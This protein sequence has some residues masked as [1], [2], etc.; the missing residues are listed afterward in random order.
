MKRKGDPQK[1]ESPPLPPLHARWGWRFG[2][3]SRARLRRQNLL[4]QGCVAASPWL[5][6]MAAFG[7]VFL[8]APRYLRQRGTL[9]ELPAAPMDEGSLLMM[10]AVLLMPLDNGA[11]GAGVL[12][13]HDD[14]R[15]RAENPAELDRFAESLA[16][17]VS[18]G[19]DEVVLLADGRVSHEWVM[20][21]AHAA[22]KAGMRRVNIAARQKQEK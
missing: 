17:E 3:T 20:A 12:V 18:A 13:L 11:E 16:R 7:M 1:M 8:A 14:L 2:A 15:H 21:V 19:R 4:F 5:A 9:F 10:P 22:R 6:V